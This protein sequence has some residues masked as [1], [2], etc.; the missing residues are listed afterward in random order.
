MKSES[1]DELVARVSA[2]GDRAGDWLLQTTLDS[3]SALCIA[4]LVQLGLKHPSVPRTVRQQGRLF[5]EGIKA[6]FREAG[7]PAHAEML[8]ERSGWD[9]QESTHRLK[10]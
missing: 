4:G 1:E 3:D 2:E 6:R 7:L 10:M 9:L 8:D 5:L